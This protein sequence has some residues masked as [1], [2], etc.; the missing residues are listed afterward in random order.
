M[1]LFKTVS[2]TLLCSCP[3]LASAKDI[4]ICTDNNFW[5]PFTFVKDGN[6]AGLHVD[7]VH[8]ALKNLGYQVTFK[9]L[10][11]KRCLGE[12]EEGKV[13][14]VATASYK[15]ERAVFLY[16]PS[17]AKEAK[18]SKWRVTQ[19][20]YVVITSKMDKMGQENTYAFTGDVASIPE[21]ARMPSGYSI[22]DSLK[23]KG[24]KVQ[25]SHSADANFKKLLRDQSGSIVDLP[26][27]AKFYSTKPAFKGKLVIHPQ[28]IK[29]K[30]YYLPF[31]K[32]GQFSTDE[33]Q[34]VWDEIANVRENEAK[35]S[36][37][38]EKY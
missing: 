19:V 38:L 6:A 21:P 27:V 18:E 29:S 10:P 31:T 23:E 9:P 4:T 8:E 22:I 5:Y 20:A 14:A 15:D 16:Y 11:W 30:S 12:A 35:V 2:M 3:I 7:I 32:K 36:S 13:D 24:L 17:D 1:R 28:P 37:F 33:A 26:E 34:K 25:T